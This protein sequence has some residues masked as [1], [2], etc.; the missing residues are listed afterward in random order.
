MDERT[1]VSVDWLRAHLDAPGLVILDARFS[2]DDEE[3]GQRTYLEGH[4]PG[5]LYADTATH[6]AGEII[7]GVTGRRP[8]P[9]PDVFAAQLGAWGIDETTQV[10]TYD[11]D[12]GR[13]SAARVWL[14][15]RWMGHDRVAVLDGGWQAWL[16]AGGEVTADV[17]AP[18]T[19]A[20]PMRLRPELLADVDEVD[21]YRQRPATCVFDSRGAEGYHGGGVYHDPVRGHIAG[22]GLADRANTTNADLTFRTPEELRAYYLDLLDGVDPSE[23]I[24]YCGSGIT[25]AQNVLAMSIAGLEGSRMYVGSWSEWITDPTRPVEL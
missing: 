21:E 22:A 1:I 14:M 20:Y 19:A 15:L 11:A 2:L 8:F 17:P 25:A 3:W 4:I 16:A 18:A 13:M 12:G 24:Y 6:L 10:V 7:P 5:A 9:E 23:V